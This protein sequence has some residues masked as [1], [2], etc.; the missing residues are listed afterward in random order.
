MVM[1]TLDGNGDAMAIAAMAISADILHSYYSS[2]TTCH[3]I[4]L[5]TPDI[6]NLGW[7]LHWLLYCLLHLDS[8]NS[9]RPDSSY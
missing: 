8:A 3:N 4:L 9:E 2:L 7:H 5:L 6:S 1:A